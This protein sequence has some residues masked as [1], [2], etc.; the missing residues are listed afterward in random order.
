MIHNALDFRLPISEG[1]SVFNILQ[2]LGI[3]SKF[4]TFPDEGHWVLKPENSLVWHRE[5]LGW[6]NRWTEA[7]ADKVIAKM[8]KVQAVLKA[9]DEL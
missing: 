3:P 9:Q 4:L 6:I 7:R 8:G 5:V 2:S 1:L